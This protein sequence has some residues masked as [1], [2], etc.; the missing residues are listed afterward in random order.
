MVEI[1]LFATLREGRDKVVYLDL[2]QA[3]CPGD[4]V[5]FL[6]IDPEQIAICLI[7]GFH[8]KLDS[9]LKDQDVLSLFPPVAGG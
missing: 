5:E 6:K 4:V 2:S 8:G 9:P 3:K 1:R 7:N